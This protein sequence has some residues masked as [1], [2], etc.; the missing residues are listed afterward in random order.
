MPASRNAVSTL[1]SSQRQARRP[2]SHVEEV[3]VEALV[4]GGIG[5]GTVGRVGKETQRRKRPSHRVS[6]V[7]KPY[8]TPLG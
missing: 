4:A 5:L 7:M 6:R 3:I 2:L 8:S 1:D